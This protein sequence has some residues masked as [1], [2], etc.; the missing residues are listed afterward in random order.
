MELGKKRA[1]LTLVITII[2]ITIV[3]SYRRFSS[4]L[5]TT[6]ETFNELIYYYIFF[7]PFILFLLEKCKSANI[8]TFLYGL[9]I[10][11]I[12]VIF[13]YILKFS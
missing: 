4:S 2:L 5:F 9:S 3:R 8:K 11:N 1:Y 6:Q 13:Y 10:I 7:F 12:L